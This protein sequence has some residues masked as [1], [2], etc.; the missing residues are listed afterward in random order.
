MFVFR[1]EDKNGQGFYDSSERVHANLSGHYYCMH[2]H[3]NPEKNLRP[4]D[5][6]VFGFGTIEKARKW[7]SCMSDLQILE[8]TSIRLCVWH[9][10]AVCNY[11]E[12]ETQSVF[13]KIPGNN[14]M[15]FL[16]SSLHD[17]NLENMIRNY[18]K[19]SFQRNQSNC[20]L[21]YQF[22]DYLPT[23]LK[24]PQSSYSQY[25]LLNVSELSV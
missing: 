11:A 21:P 23:S 6:R 10:D 19:D 14:P 7:F 22:L 25:Q 1:L 3:P 18:R 24:E 12:S 4:I 15:K 2:Q 20:S 16:P 17:P 9:R 13:S 5:G 8:N